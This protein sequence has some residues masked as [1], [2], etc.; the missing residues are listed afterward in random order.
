MHSFKRKEQKHG[1]W[2]QEEFLL[3]TSF[4]IHYLGDIYSL[5]VKQVFFILLCV[6]QD[7]PCWDTRLTEQHLCPCFVFQISRET[8]TYIKHQNA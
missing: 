7:S 1:F 5:F 6:R 3:T 8:V 2:S 4:T